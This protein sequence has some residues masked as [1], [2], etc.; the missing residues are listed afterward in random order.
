MSITVG[1]CT[2]EHHVQ[3][4]NTQTILALFLIGCMLVASIE[5]K[6]SFVFSQ[7]LHITVSKIHQDKLWYVKMVTFVHLR[8]CVNMCLFKLNYNV[9]KL[10]AMTLVS[11][12]QRCIS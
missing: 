8:C 5:G 4:M 11:N 2:K 12:K 7:F 1:I 9:H 6:L 3:T 10:L